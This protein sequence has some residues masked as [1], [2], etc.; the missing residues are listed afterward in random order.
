MEEKESVLLHQISECFFFLSN[1]TK[2]QICFKR[3]LFAS[4]SLSLCVCVCVCKGRMCVCMYVTRG[5]KGRVFVF[6]SLLN[7]L[8]LVSKTRALF[9]KTKLCIRKRHISSLSNQNAQ[10][11]QTQNLIQSQQSERLKQPF[12]ASVSFIRSSKN[13]LD[14]RTKSFRKDWNS[15]RTMTARSSKS[16]TRLPSDRAVKL[17]DEDE[18]EEK[19]K[20][21]TTMTMKKKKISLVGLG[22]PKNTVDAEVILGDMKRNDFEIVENHEDA[23]AIII[24]SCG[25]IDDAKSESVQAILEAARLND[26]LDGKRK[27]KIVVTGCLAQRYGED[28]QKELPEADFVVGFENYAML[29]DLIGDALGRTRN[30]SSTSTTTATTTT[31]STIVSP[32]ALKNTNV[33]TNTDLLIPKKKTFIG[34]NSPPFRSEIERHRITPKHSAYLRVAEGCDHKCTFCAIPSFRGKFRS[35]KFDPIIDEA[36]ALGQLGAKELCL[37]AEDTNQWGMDLRQQ[38]GRGLAELLEKLAE[39]DGIEWIRILYAYPSYFSEELITAIADIPEVCKYIDIPLQHI[40]NLSLLRMNRPPRQHAEDLLYKLRDRIPNLALRTT[41]IS[42]FPGETEEEHEELM[43]F[44]REFKFER[45]GAFAYSEEDGT[46]AAQYPDQVNNDTRA[47]RRDQLVA[48]QQEISE[49]FAVS[50]VGETM[51][52][53]IDNWDEDMQAWVGRSSLEAPDIDPVVFVS[54]DADSKT[55]SS[56]SEKIEPGQMRKCKIVGSSLFDLEAVCL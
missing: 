3:L 9:Q 15:R 6:G 12:I 47:L 28:L 30:S 35:K 10:R 38:D 21:T 11:M 41:F 34:T 33:I 25:F 27:K 1:Q 22:C 23:D 44:C 46:P 39:V 24:N 37:I 13:N 51:N 55:S 18:E 14:R 7:F 49:Q 56:A 2:Q 8:H 48:Q 29:P 17:K 54:E 31:S 4:L 19:K 32:F 26:G 42:G 53:L 36:K 52:V 20:M 45:L 50:R 43:R 40:T 5:R 16:E